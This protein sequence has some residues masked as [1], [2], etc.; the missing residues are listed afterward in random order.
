MLTGDGF[1]ARG[2]NRVLAACGRA[3]GSRHMHAANAHPH[4]CGHGGFYCGAVSLCFL[5]GN[6]EYVVVERQCRSHEEHR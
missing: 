5:I 1:I 4:Q 6:V 3:L 2:Q